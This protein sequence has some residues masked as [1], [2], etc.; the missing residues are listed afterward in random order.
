MEEQN[1]II[2]S[3]AEQEVVAVP[4][5][6]TE[7]TPPETEV[8]TKEETE[9]D[10][11]IKTKV[12][13]AFAKRLSKEREKVRAE[14]ESEY[15]P[16]KKILERGA[17]ESGMT[18][19]EYK[20]A[21][22]EEEES[23]DDIPL[24]DDYKE[25]L[26]DLKAERE[27]KRLADEEAKAY[28]ETEVVLDEYTKKMTNMLVT[29][30]GIKEASQIPDEV[31]EKADTDG[32]DIFEAFVEWDKQKSVKEAEQKTIEKIQKQGTPGSLSSN[33]GTETDIDIFK[34]KI[35]TPEWDKFKADV[36]SGKKTI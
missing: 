33:F 6:A 30:Y 24:P 12:E 17:K 14:L 21:L 15:I 1:T 27:A 18:L 11:G 13:E 23:T 31:W 10:L 26:E 29:K 36:R 28:S 3:G 16:M 25:I 32:T 9:P 7:T 34:L 4:E 19:D 2:E 8:E 22:L 35:G 5:V 20:T